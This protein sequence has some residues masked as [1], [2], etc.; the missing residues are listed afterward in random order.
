MERI[1]QF[2]ADDRAS[3]EA[4]ST[5]LLI[6]AVSIFLGAML[7]AWWTN[8]GGFFNTAGSGIEDLGTRAQSGIGE[9][10]K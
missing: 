1:R 7:V 5:V 9:L 8:L 6:G 4:T 3:A 2:L 10:K